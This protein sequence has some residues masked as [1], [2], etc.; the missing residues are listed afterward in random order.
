MNRWRGAGL[1]AFASLAG[2]V[3]LADL[4]GVGLR[5]SGVLAYAVLLAASLTLIVGLHANIAGGRAPDAVRTI[6][7]IAFVLRLAVGLGLARGLPDLGYEN[8]AENKGYVFWDAYKRDA[9]AWQRARG[10]LPLVASFT[11]PKSS[12]Q[13]GGL[14]FISAGIYRYLGGEVQRPLLIVVVTAALSAM[15]VLLAWAFADS[16][17]GAKAGIVAAWVSALT[18]EAVLLGASQMRESFLISGLAMSLYGY[19]RVR[20]EQEAGGVLWLLGGLAVLLFISPPTALIGVAVL[21]PLAVWERGER[22]RIA[23]WVWWMAVPVALVGLWLVVQSWARLEQIRGSLGEILVQ[24][25][26][27]A[28]ATWRVTQAAAGSDMLQVVFYRLPPALHLPFLVAYGLVQPFLPA[29]IAA[30][31]NPLWKTIAIIRSLGWFALVPF[32]IYGT[33]TAIR[34]RGWR[35]LESYLGLL[36]WVSAVLASYRAPGYQWDNP[37]Y[38][39]VF[40]AAQAALAGWAWVTAR[41]EGDPWLRRTFIGLGLATVVVLDWYLGRFAAFPSLSLGATILAVLLIVGGYLGVCLGRDRR[42]GG[43]PA[44]PLSAGAD[45][46]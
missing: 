27:N 25:W 34:R 21:A 9:D 31:G 28:G 43:R 20:R 15:G 10:D 3:V 46:V 7:L 4:D 42:A 16:G 30:P 40:L 18:P 22:P 36:V 35:S 29:S 45:D 38:R 44:A 19:V 12:D 39:A 17:I 37:R 1:I 26:Q 13:Y 6:A 14:L 41:A 8:T 33:V 23:R 2:A 32:L 24:W 5:L 11:D